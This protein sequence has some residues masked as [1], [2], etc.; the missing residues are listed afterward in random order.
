MATRRY[1][2]SVKLIFCLIGSMVVI[3]GLHG[4]ISVT[5]HRQHLERAIITSALRISDTIKSSTHHDMLHY[6]SQDI[7]QI[8]NTI[9]AERGI[10]RIR[11]FNKQGRIRYST[12]HREQEQF[13]DTDAEACYVCHAQEE[14]LTKLESE[15]RWRVFRTNDGHRVLGLINPI[16]NEPACSTADCHQH[17]PNEPLLGVLDVNMSLAEVDAQIGTDVMSLLS[18]YVLTILAIAV[19][20]GIFVVVMVHRPV[21]KLIDGTQRVARGELNHILDVRS[22]D[23]IGLLAA[24]FNAMT[25]DLK[26]A[27]DEI[28]NWAQTLEKRVAEKTR[29]LKRAQEQIIRVEKMVSLGKLSAI[30]AHEINNPLTGVLTYAKLMRRKLERTLRLGEAQTAEEAGECEKYLS[31]IESETARCGEIVKNLLLFS[32]KTPIQLQPNDLNSLLEK[33]TMLVNHQM[34]LQSIQLVLDLDPEIPPVTCDAGQVQQMLVALLINACEAIGEEGRIKVSSAYVHREKKVRIEVADNGSGMDARTRA[35]IF[36][37]FFTT[38]EGAIGSGLGLAVVY[39][40]VERHGGF[41]S[42]ETELGKGTTFIIELP[43]QPTEK[44]ELLSR[45]EPP[46][47]L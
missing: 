14:P 31:I 6:Q 15:Q 35:R 47:R 13:V 1:S 11:I 46:A 9:G 40:I 3:F 36:E 4:F 10:E 8:I 34:E 33:S 38:K 19:V 27:R 42:V 2:L 30:V 41:I 29:E 37:P 45:G 16:E 24:S 22:K 20:S 12:D 23:E 26:Q 17:P 28:T 44:V 43:L 21:K 39:G 5:M 7:Y 18:A 32:K 25:S